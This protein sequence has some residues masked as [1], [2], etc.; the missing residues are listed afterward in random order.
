MRPAVHSG[1][2]TWREGDPNGE[3]EFALE[4]GRVVN[5]KVFF[6]RFDSGTFEDG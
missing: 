5:L 6:L 1:R 2:K 3:A 4:G